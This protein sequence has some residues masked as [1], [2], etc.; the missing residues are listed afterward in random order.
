MKGDMSKSGTAKS[1]IGK[2][3][4]GVGVG[5]KMGAGGEVDPTT[6]TATRKEGNMGFMSDSDLKPNSP[7]G[8]T[9]SF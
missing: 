9:K 8:N 2:I 4:E 1:N 5:P 7:G 3:K 6:Q